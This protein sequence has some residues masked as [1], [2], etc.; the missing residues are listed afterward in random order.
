MNKEVW[1]KEISYNER[2]EMQNILKSYCILFW[3]TQN[4]RE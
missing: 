3:A 1:E 2:V 4:K